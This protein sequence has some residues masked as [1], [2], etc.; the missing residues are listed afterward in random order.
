V[1][2]APDI[3]PA[4]GLSVDPRCVEWIER[5]GGRTRIAGPGEAAPLRGAGGLLLCGGCFDIPPDWYGEE[6]VARVDAPREARSRFELDLARGAERLDLAV[7]GICGGEQLM[8]V[9][10]GG[11]LVQDIATQVPGALDHERGAEDARAVHAV[12][13]ERESALR[14]TFGAPEIRVNSTHHQSVREPGRG[15]RVAG[16]APDS[17]VEAIEDPALRFWIGVQ[18]HPERLAEPHGLRLA[19]AFVRAAGA[20]EPA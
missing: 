1:V 5:A 15:V 9:A 18:W 17:I 13:L 6:G 10:R 4:G 14:E 20:V 12:R 16:R 11:S 8:A 2:I 3:D 7:L 19:E